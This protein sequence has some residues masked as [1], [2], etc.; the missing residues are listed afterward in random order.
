[1]SEQGIRHLIILVAWT[2]LIVRTPFM[3]RDRRQRPLWLVLSAIAGGSIVIQSWFGAALNHATGVPHMNNLVQGL[4][5][6]AICV[7]L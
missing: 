4:L 5:S 1:M 7:I 2:V 3:I 6:F